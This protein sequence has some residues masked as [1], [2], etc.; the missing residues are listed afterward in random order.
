[1]YSRKGME[2]QILSPQ[3][4]YYKVTKGY[5]MLGLIGAFV[6][7]ALDPVGFV[8]DVSKTYDELSAP[9]KKLEALEQ[10]NRLLKAQI[11]NKK[12]KSL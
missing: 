12:Y 7:I 2:V 5:I 9:R 1:M 11:E 8:S 10:E 6:D 3:P 4:N